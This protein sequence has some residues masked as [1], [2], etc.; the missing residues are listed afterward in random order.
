[1]ALRKHNLHPLKG[2]M[3]NASDDAL[4]DW[5]AYEDALNARFSSEELD[6]VMWSTT[7]VVQKP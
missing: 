7:L 1:V 5:F 3:R 6:R 2:F 4:L